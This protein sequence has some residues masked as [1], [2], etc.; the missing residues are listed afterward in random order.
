MTR[1]KK[2][3]SMYSYTGL[4]AH[5]QLAM[6][7]SASS[8]T[9]SSFPLHWHSSPQRSAGHAHFNPNSD[10]TNTVLPVMAMRSIAFKNAASPCIAST[11]PNE[12]T[13][14]LFFASLLIASTSARSLGVMLGQRARPSAFFLCS[15]SRFSLAQ[16][17]SASSIASSK[18]SHAY[19]K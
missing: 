2:F 14:L 7:R 8:S 10:C 18:G 11:S 4:A 15:L 17:R 1:G 12:S 3:L 9:P 5:Q 16:C 19:A 6:E 13:S